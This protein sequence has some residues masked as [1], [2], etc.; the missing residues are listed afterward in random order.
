MPIQGERETSWTD[1]SRRPR[2]WLEW[3]LRIACEKGGP[4][5]MREDSRVAGPWAIAE[6]REQSRRARR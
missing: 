2:A 3:D 6:E 5:L 4:A 1:V